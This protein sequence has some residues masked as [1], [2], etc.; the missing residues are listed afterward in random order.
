MARDIDVEIKICSHTENALRRLC[1]THEELQTKKEP[2]SY[3]LVCLHYSRP[4]VVI[5]AFLNC[6]KIQTFCTDCIKT[7]TPIQNKIFI[8][9]I[10][11]KN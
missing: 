5:S 6:Y 8:T 9:W 2:S 11:N 10:N 1:K 4:H 7:A 3:C